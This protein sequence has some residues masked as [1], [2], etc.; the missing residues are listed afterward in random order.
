MTNVI[1]RYSSLCTQPIGVPADMKAARIDTKQKFGLSVDLSIFHQ[2]SGLRSELPSGA[3]PSPSNR[4]DY[5][6]CSPASIGLGS[7]CVLALPID[8]MVKMVARV[9][10]ALDKIEAM[11]TIPDPIGHPCAASGD[12]YVRGFCA[13]LRHGNFTSQAARPAAKVSI[14]RP[15]NH[16]HEANKLRS[17]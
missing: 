5:A 6:R 2:Y 14:Y 13:P 4:T 7:G 8:R 1:S 16:S 10:G 11:L 3:D 17:N 15:R 12:L 9:I